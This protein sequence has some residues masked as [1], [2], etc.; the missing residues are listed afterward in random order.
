MAQAGGIVCNGCGWPCV[1]GSSANVSSAAAGVSW[2][3]R[4]RRWLQV[5]ADGMRVGCDPSRVNLASVAALAVCVQ[6][7]KQ[8]ST[9]GNV[10]SMGALFML[11]MRIGNTSNN[12]DAR[13]YVW[14]F[15]AMRCMC[16]GIYGCTYGAVLFAYGIG[17]HNVR[18]IVHALLLHALVVCQRAC[19]IGLRGI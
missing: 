15:H 12:K 18:S 1:S 14:G 5:L 8:E 13:L 9:Q 3:N 19:N 16:G 17:G 10:C 6:D 2:L 11:Y 4:W 7:S